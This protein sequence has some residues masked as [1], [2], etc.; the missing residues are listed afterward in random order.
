MAER[1]HVRVDPAQRFGR[2][3]VKGISVQVIADMVWTGESIGRLAE[4]YG[5]DRAD[6]LVA[7]WFAGRH[8]TRKWRKRWGDWALAAYNQMWN[9]STVDYR[10]VPDPPSR[11]S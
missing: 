8:G 7:C 3:N 10:A 5:I 4:N 9:A 6:V 2:P 11:E 1:P